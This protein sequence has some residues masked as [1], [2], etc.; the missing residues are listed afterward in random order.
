MCLQCLVPKNVL[1]LCLESCSFPGLNN[2]K[3]GINRVIFRVGKREI[4]V[5]YFLVDVYMRFYSDWKIHFICDVPCSDCTICT[6]LNLNF[7]IQF[8]PC[9]NPQV[10]IL[11]RE[12]PG[13]GYFENL[14]GFTSQ[15]RHTTAY[16]GYRPAAFVHTLRNVGNWLILFLPSYPLVAVLFRCYLWRTKKFQKQNTCKDLNANFGWFLRMCFTKM[17][18]KPRPKP[19]NAKLGKRK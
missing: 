1:L 6:D 16:G 8:K 7:L 3:N 12:L 9:P 17:L 2:R 14:L 15:F 19:Q 11:L 4:L 5:Q 10:G 18:P 13:W